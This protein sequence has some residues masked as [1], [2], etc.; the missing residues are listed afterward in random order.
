VVT[1]I[2]A[3]R[4]SAV[5]TPSGLACLS[6]I[7]TINL[8][9]G[10]LHDCAYCYIRG[11]RNYPGEGRI[12]LYQNTLDLL[13]Y[14]LRQT[15]AKPRAV[16]FSPSSDLFQPAPEVLELSH[17]VLDFL[18]SEGIGVAFLTKGT[19]PH[20]TLRLFVA[21]RELVQAQ[22]GLTTLDEHISA[23]FEPHAASPETRLGQL[24]ALIAGGVQTQ[25]RLDPILPNLTGSPHSLERHFAALAQ[26]GVRRVAAGVL[27]LRPAILYW[28]RRNVTDRGVLALLLN[29]FRD[30]QEAVMRG[31]EYP[32]R[33]L[34]LEGRR[35]IFTRLEEITAARGIELK[36]CACKN[37]DL[38]QGSCN[39]AGTWPRRSRTAVQ[40]PLIVG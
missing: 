23:V 16:Y 7:P 36:V 9:A 20:E 6:S 24:E 31:A 2:R 22:I 5:L 27:F 33:N 13:R 11:Y 14:E 19:I 4:R 21:H 37:P 30:G 18:L 28:L 29:S 1:V 34:S 26:I 40:P 8:T 10:C 38:A 35:E 25:A 39:I 17:A 12:V 3:N 32:I 15:D